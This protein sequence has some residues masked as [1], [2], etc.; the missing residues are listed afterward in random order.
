MREMDL[1][2]LHVRLAG[3]DDREGGGDGP[4]VVLMHGFG[5]SGSDLVPLWR[6]L[7]VPPGTRFVFPEAPHSL[8]AGPLG[9]LMD[10]RAWWMIDVARIEQAIARGEE[11]DLSREIPDGLPEARALVDSML[12]ALEAELGVPDSGVVLGGFSQG[13]MLATDVVLRSRRKFAGLVVMSGTLLAADEWRELLPARAGLRVLQSHG[14]VDPLLPYG[15][16]ERLRDLMTEAGLEVQFIPFN[17][18][19]GIADS[20]LEALGPFVRDVS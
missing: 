13:A 18:A 17:G 6:A 2:G 14:R 19:H 4:V 7:E 20:V 3:G 10:S 9:G 8:E 15:A 16:A 12:D 5:A 11:R 1:G